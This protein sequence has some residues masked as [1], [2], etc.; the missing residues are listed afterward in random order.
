MQVSSDAIVGFS[1]K[2]PSDD[3]V[4]NPLGLSHHLEFQNRLVPG[5]TSVTKRA[6]YYTLQAWYYEHLYEQ[7]VISPKDFERIFILACLAHHDGDSSHPALRHVH[8]KTRFDGTW[9][10]T[11]R[12]DLDFKITGDGRGYYVSQLET[13]R[14]AWTDQLGQ[15]RYTHLNQKLAGSIDL[16]PSL[17]AG[18]EFTKQQLKRDFSNLCICNENSREIDVLSKLFFGFFSRT[19]HGWNLDRTEFE[20]FQTG[21]IK[22]AFDDELT[23]DTRDPEEQTRQE[24]LRRRNTLF[25]FLKIIGHV[26]PTDA[27]RAIWDAVYFSQDRQSKE[28]IA[29]GSLD[30]ARQYWEF[31]Q[32]N[33]YYVY[34]LESLLEV[35]QDLIRANHGITQQDLLV[36][37][38]DTAVRE[39]IDAT[40]G[41]SIETV[42]DVPSSIEAR[43]GSRI[44]R[45]TDPV[46]ES[47]L[48]DRINSAR[49]WQE[50]TA[51]SLLM[52]Q[53]LQLRY[54][55]TPDYIRRQVGARNKK[56]PIRD[57]LDI[58]TFFSDLDSSHEDNVIGWLQGLVQKIKRRHLFE[59]ASRLRSNNTRAWLFTEEDGQLFSAR[60]R[61]FSA[62]TRDNRWDSIESLLTDLNFIQRDG[63]HLV[64][65]DRGEQW[66]QRID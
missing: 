65:T 24:N 46:N 15:E 23:D 25:L 20:Q 12:F 56:S 21:D 32:L 6:R 47:E 28:D 58:H 51:A 1:E 60:Q 44:T 37:F 42:A 50:K 4:L 40:L 9:D 57:D 49:N 52:L 16:E 48:F 35:V 38:E 41:T 45:L 55:L 31:F 11:E 19:D 27:S 64:L 53:T 3:R 5:I 18:R 54:D 34:A 62:S 26:Q 39:H 61:P 63:D 29:F 33:V 43:N 30:R 36:R 13:F 8:N 17:F 14:C 59:A 66:L 22:L 10:D 2:V 7:E